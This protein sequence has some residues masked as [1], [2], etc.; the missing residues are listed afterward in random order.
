MK[1]YRFEKI[2][3]T[4]TAAALVKHLHKGSRAQAPDDATWVNETAKRFE[5]MS[6]NKPRTDTMEHFVDDLIK[7]D[8]LDVL[9]QQ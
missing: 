3:F 6:G 7:D 1:Q 5:L 9:V 4:G 2:N 8:L